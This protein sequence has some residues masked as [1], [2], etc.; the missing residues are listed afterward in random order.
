[1][2]GLGSYKSPWHLAHHVRY[3]MRQEPIKG[4]LTG[5]VESDETWVGPRLRGN[6]KG[7]KIENKTAVQALIQRDGPMRTRVIGRVN[8]AGIIPQYSHWRDGDPSRSS[9]PQV[10]KR[11]N[12]RPLVIGNAKQTTRSW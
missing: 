10:V 8:K 3:A 1:M 7:L 9:S 4:M 2:L 6:G 11:E 5:T 12:R